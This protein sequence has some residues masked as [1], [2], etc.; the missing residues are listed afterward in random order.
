VLAAFPTAAKEEMLSAFVPW[1][2]DECIR[3]FESEGKKP[4]QGVAPQNLALHQGIAWSNSASALGLRSLAVENRV[5]SRCTG[6]ER[7][8]ES[9]L[10]MFGARYY[11]SS[12]GRFMT[13]DWSRDPDPVPYADLGDPQSLN[14]YGYVRN[15]PLARRDGDGHKTV[16]APDTATWGPN[17]VTVTA[18]ACHDEP[19]PGPPLLA[20]G[21]AFG[22]HF[23]DQSLV[24]AKGAWD[25]LSGQF[26]QRWRTGPLQNPG[27]HKGFTTAHR[28]N[29]AQ[30]RDIVAKVEQQSG[31][32][33]AQ[34]NE[35]DINKAVDEVRGAGGDVDSFLSKIA[36]DNPTARTVGEDAGAVMDAAKNAY[37]AIQQSQ[38]GQAVEGIVEDVETA[39]ESEPN[40]G[41]PP[42]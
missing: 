42:P 40:C 25:S 3:A 16:C 27:L 22:H 1:S 41:L 37:N 8:A 33:M 32:A 20:L 7:D 26:F 9:G 2:A 17:G 18:G 31:R 38:A 4:H 39:C 30:I 14:L 13:P 19:D 23:V 34:W 6:K 29:S 10:D 5:R 28:L 11:G 12:M 36:S 21:M 15:N 35:E 24:R